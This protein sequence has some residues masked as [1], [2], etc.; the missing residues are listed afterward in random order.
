[1]SS[2][3]SLLVDKPVFSDNTKNVFMDMKEFMIMK[4]KQKK[5]LARIKKQ[6]NRG[7]K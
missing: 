2:E 6:K 5:I 7:K 1:L 4:E 3:Q